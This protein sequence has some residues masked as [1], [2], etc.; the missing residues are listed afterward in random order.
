MRS[1]PA[2]R[3]TCLPPY[4]FAELDR[5]RRETAARGLDIIDLGI[6]DPDLPTPE[7]I[8]RALIEAAG[9]PKTH[10]YPTYQGMPAFRETA[11]RSC[12]NVSG[13]T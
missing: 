3:L 10:R 11:A 9:N 2:R 13:S 5:K 1:I 8:V 7:P 4:L 12:A 6:G